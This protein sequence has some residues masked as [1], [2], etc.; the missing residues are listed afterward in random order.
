MWCHCWQHSGWNRNLIIHTR[1][2]VFHPYPHLTLTGF[3][4]FPILTNLTIAS[5]HF[6][7]SPMFGIHKGISDPW[8]S[9]I[10][11]CVTQCNNPEDLNPWTVSTC[12]MFV[13]YLM[14]AIAYPIQPVTTV[15]LMSHTYYLTTHLTVWGSKQCCSLF[16]FS[17]LPFFKLQVTQTKIYQPLL[18][19]DWPHSLQPTYIYI[20]LSLP[21]LNHFT[22]LDTIVPLKMEM[23]YFC[24]ISVSTHNPTQH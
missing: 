21:S 22:Y 1:S 18:S 23:A 13:Q 12:Q 8:K 24:E 15:H 17:Q 6:Q 4:V 9:G 7:L 11:N 3:P 10:N 2:E 16:W 19:Y 14:V 5:T 20:T